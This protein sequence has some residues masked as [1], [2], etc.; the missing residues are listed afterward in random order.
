MELLQQI[1]SLKYR[2]EIN[3]MPTVHAI[4]FTYTPQRE[5]APM[6][7]MGTPDPRSF[8][9]RNKNVVG[10]IYPVIGDFL[11]IVKEYKFSNNSKQNV[12]SR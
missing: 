12:Y 3:L 5:K 6:F 2:N 1:N 8:S 7:I 9:R 11:S 10:T 4:E